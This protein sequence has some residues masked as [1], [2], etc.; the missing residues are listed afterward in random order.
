MCQLFSVCPLFT[1]NTDAFIT[2]FLPLCRSRRNKTKFAEAKPFTDKD[3]DESAHTEAAEHV[4]S[5]SAHTETAK[6]VRTEIGARALD[7]EQTTRSDTQEA[8]DT[9]GQVDTES[10]DLEDSVSMDG[11]GRK[12]R[13][14]KKGKKNKSRNQN[15]PKTEEK[16]IPS[17]HIVCGPI[18]INGVTDVRNSEKDNESRKPFKELTVE[19]SVISDVPSAAEFC[20]ENGQVSVDTNIGLPSQHGAGDSD[21]TEQVSKENEAIHDDVSVKSQESQAVV[22]GCE[23]PVSSTGVDI[24]SETDRDEGGSTNKEKS[25]EELEA[26]DAV[27]Q[28]AVMPTTVSPSLTSES[29]AN[30]AEHHERRPATVSPSL[31]SESKADPAEHHERRPA[32]V[33]PSLT[34]ESKADL[35]E[36]QERRP[37]KQTAAFKFAH[38]SKTLLRRKISHTL[39]NVDL[40]KCEP[41][42]VVSL[43]KL[44][45]VQTFGALKKKLRS[46]TKDWMQVSVMFM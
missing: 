18:V 23:F 1:A 45:S 35:D 37:A 22:Q 12:K 4:R 8:D 24:K 38:G 11:G 21:C 5:E 9:P 15:S 33:S 41:E 17:R 27:T 44:P 39:F 43:L 13:D 19:T 32:T 7:V 10:S 34:S 31:K 16:I 26:S 46:S 6:H 14:S 25:L 40:E 36:H 29:K 20:I 42:I 2:E 28:L 3:V 30:L